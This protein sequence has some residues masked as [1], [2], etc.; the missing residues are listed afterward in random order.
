MLSFTAKK[1]SITKN[2]F[3][4]QEYLWITKLASNFQVV[5]HILSLFP[6]FTFSYPCNGSESINL[7]SNIENVGFDEFT[8]YEVP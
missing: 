4:K 3:G 8:S 2:K 1:L 5:V 7:E 6:L